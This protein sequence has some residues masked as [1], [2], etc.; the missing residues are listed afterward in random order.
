MSNVVGL[1]MKESL[2]HADQSQV[3]D[4]DAIS[5]MKRNEM[6]FPAS[7][8]YFFKT[9]MREKSFKLKRYSHANYIITNK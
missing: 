6:P 4:T 8:S 7:F 5:I 3:S 2:P 1:W 9:L